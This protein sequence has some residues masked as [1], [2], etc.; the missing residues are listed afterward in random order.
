M[1]I[2][3]IKPERI[4][5]KDNNSAKIYFTYTYMYI[6]RYFIA[7]MRIR[8]VLPFQWPR[9]LPATTGHRARP[10]LRHPAHY[11]LPRVNFH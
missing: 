4:M 7:H 1:N 2:S 10:R 3:P 9:Y 11:E 6:V 8:G 5:T